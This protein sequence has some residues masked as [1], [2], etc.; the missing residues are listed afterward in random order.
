[1]FSLNK[2]HIYFTFYL[3]S[4]LFTSITNAQEKK[5]IVN[6]TIYD[7]T[8]ETVPFVTVGILNKAIGTA[9][10]E[11]GEFALLVTENELNDTLYVSSLG[12]DT[13]KIKVKEYINKKDRKIILKENIVSLDAVK[14]LH[15]IDYVKNALKNLKNNTLSKTHVKEILYR[16]AATENG[17]AKFFVENYVKLKGRG[18]GYWMGTMQVTEMRKSADYR[19]WKRKQF[20]HSME[21]MN[22]ANPLTPNDSNHAVNL[23]KLNW[24]KTGSS[25]YDGNDVVILEGTQKDILN[26]ITLYVGIEDYKIYRIER[27][28]ALFI[29]KEHPSGRMCLSYYKNQWGFGNKAKIPKYV[30][31]TPGETLNY[32]L[33]AYVM[34]VITDKKKT[35]IIPYGVRMDM[36][37]LNLPYH[38]EFWKKLND[39]VP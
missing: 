5:T 4:L 38:P 17:K 28:N 21:H 36:G 9:S 13:Y 11:D 3:L 37:S 27:G 6:G 16:R 26:K 39:T 24:K 19:F 12:F 20:N 10:S 8:N 2:K 35:K 15:P 7:E 30:H 29:Y 14:L 32:K 1:M 33:E 23:K 34:D 25:S 22:N 18:P 31:G